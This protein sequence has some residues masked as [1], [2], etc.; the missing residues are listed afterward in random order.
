MTAG[1][2]RGTPNEKQESLHGAS[3]M[4]LSLLRAPAGREMAPFGRGHGCLSSYDHL[5]A[6]GGVTPPPQAQVAIEVTSH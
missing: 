3:S 2:G 5:A 4:A 6:L 1:W